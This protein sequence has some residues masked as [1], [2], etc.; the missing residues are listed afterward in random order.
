MSL[1]PI[2]IVG[3]GRMGTTL[4]A[5]LHDS[6]AFREV[7]LAGRYPEPPDLPAWTDRFRYVFGLEHPPAGT[8]AVLLAIP[9]REVPDVAQA[10]AA[11]G[12]APQGCAVYHLSGVLPTDALEPLHHAGY[13]VGALHPLFFVP[14]SGGSPERIRD[15]WFSVTGGPDAV[16][17]ARVLVDSVEGRLIRVPAGRRATLHAAVAL[18][19]SMMLPLLARGLELM[20]RAGVDGDE[21]LSSL[22]SLTR[23][24]LDAIEVDGVSDALRGPIAQGDVETVGLHLRALDRGAARLYA[25]IGAEALGLAEGGL[26]AGVSSQL[27]EL[28]SRYLYPETTGTNV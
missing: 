24:T 20:E 23:S 13:V 27:E 4:A 15:A 25:A 12:P 2:M 22:I 19:T 7:V 28:L 3:P 6:G 11:L 26:E 10:L 18:T 14:H 8:L 9:E 16:S 5:A 17:V 21:G 1:G